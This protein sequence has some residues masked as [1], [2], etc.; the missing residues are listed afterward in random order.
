MKYSQLL[1]A[2]FAATV[3][4]SC[5]VHWSY[6]PSLGTYITGM[7]TTGTRFGMPGILHIAFSLIAILM[8]GI[9]RVWSKRTNIFIGAINLA[10]CLK[11]F[12]LVSMCSAGDCQEKKWGIYLLLVASAGMMLMTLLPKIQVKED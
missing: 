9:S 3:I 4:F 7:D 5:F 1:G 2:L 11:N 6:I 10:W 12:M 8:F